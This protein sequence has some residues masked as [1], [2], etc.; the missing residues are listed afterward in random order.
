ML[1]DS[2]SQA[3][4]GSSSVGSPWNVTVRV[5]PLTGPLLGVLVPPELP[6]P[7]QAAI[8]RTRAA[9]SNSASTPTADLRP[10]ISPSPFPVSYTHLRA[11]E[12]GRNLVCRLLLEKKKKYKKKRTNKKK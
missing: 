6:E 7:P 9:S 3:T 10:F 4:A 1:H 8:P 12:T 2:I 11:H 5:P